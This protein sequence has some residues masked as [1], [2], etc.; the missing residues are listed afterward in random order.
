VLT[1]DYFYPCLMRAPFVLARRGG[2]DL[3]AAWALVSS[4]AADAARLKDR[5]RLAMGQRA[6]VVL[7]ADAGCEPVAVVTIAEGRVAWLSADGAARLEGQGQRPWTPQRA[8]RPFDPNLL[9]AS[10]HPRRGSK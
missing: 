1:S 4:N 8:E 9:G 7:V 5:G 10:R 2:L 3:A 6:D